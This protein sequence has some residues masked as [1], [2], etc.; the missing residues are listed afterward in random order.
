M[1]E[2]V[3]Y[4]AIKRVIFGLSRGNLEGIIAQYLW[5]RYPD[6]AVAASD[7]KY[8]WCDGLEY[9]DDDFCVVIKDI[10]V[11]SRDK[12]YSPRWE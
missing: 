2:G 3:E 10:C 4:R 5:D 1:K 8:N 7:L 11:D 12:M 6:H 9:S